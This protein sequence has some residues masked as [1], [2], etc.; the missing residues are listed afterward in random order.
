[1]AEPHTLYYL[2]KTGTFCVRA[3]LAKAGDTFVVWLLV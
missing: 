3:G 1:M 2:I